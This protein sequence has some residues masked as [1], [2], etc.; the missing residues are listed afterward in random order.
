MSTTP[1]TKVFHVPTGGTAQ[2]PLTEKLHHDLREPA[3][4]VDIVPSLTDNTLIS[5][6]KFTD[7]NYFAVYDDKEVNIYDGNTTKIYITEKAVL[8]GFRCPTSKLWRIPLTSNVTNQN[9]ETVLLDSPDD[10]QSLNAMYVVP[11]T[12]QIRN[13]LSILLD[14]RPDPKEAI[15]H[16]Y[17]MPSIQPAIRYLHAAAGF[18]TKSTW[19]KAIRN[20]NYMSWPL[21]TV[22]NVNKYFPESEETQQGHMKSQRQNVRSTRVKNKVHPKEV[23]VKIEPGEEEEDSKTNVEKENDI[24]IDVYDTNNTIYTDQT[25]KFPSVSS[26][27]NRYQMILTHM[28]TNS[29]WV[30]ATNNKTEGEMILAR[31]WALLHMKACGILPKHQVVDNECSASYTHEISEAGMTYQLVPQNNH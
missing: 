31:W 30:K 13:K 19:L 8:Q 25:G 24:M 28:D 9:T 7:A 10:R 29:I 2:A 5:T 15:N 22:K 12:E 14:H 27:G 18:P 11:S 4:S 17:D 3:I 1:S 23:E 26:R 21:L 20:N 16:V 6:G